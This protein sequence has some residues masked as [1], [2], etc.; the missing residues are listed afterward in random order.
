M[1]VIIKYTV[2]VRAIRDARI[3]F[4][5]FKPLSGPLLHMMPLNENVSIQCRSLLLYYDCECSHI[6]SMLH[7]SAILRSM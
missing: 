7:R 6:T 3:T 2:I 1:R 5:T 4:L